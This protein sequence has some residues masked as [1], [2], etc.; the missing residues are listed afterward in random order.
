MVT[1]ALRVLQVVNVA[2]SSPSHGDLHRIVH[3]FSGARRSVEVQAEG[4]YEEAVLV[5]WRP[6]GSLNQ[7]QCPDPKCP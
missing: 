3:G 1:L 2:L 6:Q 5:W 7:L 4:L